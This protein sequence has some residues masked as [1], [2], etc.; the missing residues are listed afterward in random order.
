MACGIVLATVIALIERFL[1]YIQDLAEEAKSKLSRGALTRISAPKFRAVLNLLS[2]SPSPVTSDCILQPTVSKSLL[3]FPSNTCEKSASVSMHMVENATGCA[4]GTR[5]RRSGP[6]LGHL[7]E[8]GCERYACHKCR[9]VD[10][11]VDQHVVPTPRIIR[12]AWI[13]EDLHHDHDCL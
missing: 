5:S 3:F 10:E 8:C 11:N 13:I 2:S 4:L 7:D 12:Q 9:R 1:N 6:E